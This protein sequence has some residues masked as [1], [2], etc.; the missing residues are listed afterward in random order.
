[1]TLIT[2]ADG[3]N[4]GDLQFNIPRINARPGKG[5]SIASVHGLIGTGM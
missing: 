1:M 2:L 5:E 4:K 3:A